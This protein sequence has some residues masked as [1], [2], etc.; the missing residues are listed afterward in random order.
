[1]GPATFHV[2][3]PYILRSQIDHTHSVERL[4]LSGIPEKDMPR[5]QRIV[6]RRPIVKGGWV[7]S[8]R[9]PATM[10]GVLSI[11][12]TVAG[13]LSI[14]PIID[15]PDYLGGCSANHHRV[16]SAALFQCVMAA[17]YVGFAVSLYPILRKYSEGLAIGFVAFRSIAGMCNALGVITILL[18]LALSRQYVEAGAPE[19]SHFQTIGSLLRTGRDVVNHL[20][21]I[22]AQSLGGLMLYRLL[23]KTR[24]VPRW[25]SG[26]GL[27]GT[28]LAILASVLVMFRLVDIMSVM[29]LGL[30]L[31]IA[32]L[33]IVVAVWLISNGFNAPEAASQ[34]HGWDPVA[35]V[36]Q[37]TV[38]RPHD[39]PV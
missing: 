29:Y 16:L 6:R 36:D 34:S 25:L 2:G 1:M 30:N 11:I 3:L 37:L 8:I 23:Y 15:G 10:A 7:S 31:P 5:V 26:W 33:E 13:V 14:S 9:Q 20:A 39:G 32:L 28:A 35:S 21:M 24:L 38:S 17:A 22:L 27:A 19:S 12:G 4:K 18:L